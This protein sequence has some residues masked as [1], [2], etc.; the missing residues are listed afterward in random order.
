MKRQ[1][2]VDL[3]K[4][5]VVIIDNDM[6]KFSKDLCEESRRLFKLYLGIQRFDGL[7]FNWIWKVDK[8]GI[9]V[10]TASVEGSNWFAI[11]SDSVIKADKYAI[12]NLLVDDERSAEYDKSVDGYEVIYRL[13]DKSCMRRYWYKALWPY[14]VRDIVIM[15][16]WTE[17]EEDGSILISSISPPTSFYPANECKNKKDSVRAV[18]MSSGA[19][20]RPLDKSVGGG[21]AVTFLTHCDVGGS[22]PS[23]LLNYYS[24]GVPVEFITNIKNILSN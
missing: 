9:I 11:K 6:E 7:N 15:T 10:H 18:V 22:V 4:S 20:I 21:C 16:C 3:L 24:T 13:D 8:N 5:K 17:N 14:A 1:S 12:C 23:S 2:L 19:L